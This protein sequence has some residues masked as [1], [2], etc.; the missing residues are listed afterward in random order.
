MAPGGSALGGDEKDGGPQVPGAL[1]HQLHRD[2]QE[3]PR[4][5]MYSLTP[6]KGGGGQVPGALTHQL[7]RN[8]Q[9]V[10]R[11]G[12][13]SLTPNPDLYQMNT[14]PKHCFKHRL[15]VCKC[16]PFVNV[17]TFRTDQNNLYKIRKTRA[18]Q[19][20]SRSLL[21]VFYPCSSFD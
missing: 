18:C 1:T 5:G 6:N 12:M 2:T 21:D 17:K 15:F 11:S 14:D 9:E 13:N 7:Y 3:V 4:R 16:L 8:T 20:M 10:P 19:I